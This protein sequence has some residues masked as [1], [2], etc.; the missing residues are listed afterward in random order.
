SV[1]L[2]QLCASRTAVAE[3]K[4]QMRLATSSIQFKQ[5]PLEQACQEIAKLGFE[6]IDIWD[7][8]DGNQHLV[9]AEKLGGDGLKELLA[10]N[11]LK[12]SGFSVYRAGYPK[13]AELLGKAG[14]GV[15]VRSCENGKFK[16]EEVSERMKRFLEGLKPLV[17]LAEKHNSWLAIENHGGS[18]LDS[19]DSFKAFVEANTSPRVGIALA[20]YHLQA[21]NASVPDVIRSCGKQLFFFY[22]WQHE[23]DFKQ[24]PGV[25]PTDMAPWLQALAEIQYP[26]YVNPFMHGHPK[27]EEMVA[28]LAKACEYLKGSWNKP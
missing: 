17:E 1:A 14:G 4:W 8:F 12:L 2:P 5:L 18:L 3:E 26:R 24:L 27:T 23:A 13:Y 6:A 22:A 20:P 28:N 16:P 15:A 25:G 19:P 10:K 21:I 11:K 7:E 9:E